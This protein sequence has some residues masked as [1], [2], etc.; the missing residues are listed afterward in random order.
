MVSFFLINF[1][2]TISCDLNE[3]LYK[4]SDLILPGLPHEKGLKLI[5]FIT[6]GDEVDSFS[7]EGVKALSFEVNGEEKEHRLI[8][9]ECRKLS[10]FVYN[11]MREIRN[12]FYIEICEKERECLCNYSIRERKKC[13]YF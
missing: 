10:L 12:E 11:N 8:V 9:E 3:I 13:F 1:I 6:V 4:T 5:D 7:C 2:F